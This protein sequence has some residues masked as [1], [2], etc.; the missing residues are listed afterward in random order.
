MDALIHSGISDDEIKQVFHE[1]AAMKACAL[2]WL[3]PNW[4]VP[5]GNRCVPNYTLYLNTGTS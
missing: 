5:E 2:N 3:V 1:F 4:Q